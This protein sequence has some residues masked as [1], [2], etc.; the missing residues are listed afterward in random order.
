M[1]PNLT[2]GKKGY[3]K[4]RDEM[5]DVAEEAQRLKDEF[6]RAIDDDTAAFNTLMDCFGLP[7]GTPAEQAA[8]AQAI[9]EATIGATEVPLPTLQAHRAHAGAVPAPSPSAAIR[10]A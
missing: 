1:V 4:V 9:L 2:V 8:R 7:K 10:T 5:N 3:K 6:L